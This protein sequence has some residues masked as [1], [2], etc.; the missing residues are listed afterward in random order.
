MSAWSYGKSDRQPL[1]L[2]RLLLCP[3]DDAA[4]YVLCQNKHRMMIYCANVIKTVLCHIVSRM[5][6]DVFIA[7]PMEELP[8][9]CSIACMRSAGDARLLLHAVFAAAAGWQPFWWQGV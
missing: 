7:G 9:M 2:E 5:D 6:V 1:V 4:R 3:R 8:G